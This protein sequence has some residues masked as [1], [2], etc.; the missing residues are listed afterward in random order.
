M[1]IFHFIECYNHH[2][3]MFQAVFDINSLRL[4]RTVGDDSILLFPYFCC[5]CFFFTRLHFVFTIELDNLE[6]PKMYTF[7]FNVE[8]NAS[9]Q[10]CV[11]QFRLMF[12]EKYNRYHYIGRTQ[13]QHTYISV[14]LLLMVLLLLLLFYICYL[15]VCWI[16]CLIWSDQK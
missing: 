3:S 11:Q 13:F 14:I 5:C 6:T 1:H 9:Q 12:S 8:Q 10:Q 2:A 15:P 7:Q 4:Y 16:E